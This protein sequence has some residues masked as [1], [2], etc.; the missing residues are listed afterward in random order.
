MNAANLTAWTVDQSGFP[1][2]G[3]TPEKARFAVRY[4]ILAPS[5]HNTQPWR[6]VI[7][8][9]ELLVCADRT[10]SLPNIDP[11]DRELA[12]FNLR[13]ALAHFNVPVEITTFPHSAEP[14]V[15]AHIVFPDSGPTLKDLA[16]LFP[17]ITKRTTNRGPFIAEDVPDAVV[18]SLKSATEM[19]GGDVK[20]SRTLRE[21]EH[22]AALIAQAD[23]RQFD[24]P[25]FR[26]ELAS[27][28]H[29]S[30]SNDGM[31]SASQGLATLTDVA[32]PIFA[33]AIRTFDLGNGIAAAHE[34]LARG[35]PL[36]VALS[37]ARD[38]NEA[39]LTV[40][41]AMQRLLLVATVAGYGTSYLNQPIEVSE[42]RAKLAAELRTA[43]Y[44]QLLLRVGRGATSPHSP[45]RPITEVLL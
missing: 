33:I 17:A 1:A 9:S 12:L 13:V 30:R 15:V 40:G 19:E 21:R 22:V 37:M 5:S 36:L 31:P 41:Q 34:Q 32:T 20:F 7:I 25:R 10:R 14:D 35:S 11:F 42:F 27:W 4:A 38:N 39:W 8:G 16:I 28:I 29:P 23:R 44:P 2:N 43:R 26:R 45:R 24:D 18:E 3:T 6:F